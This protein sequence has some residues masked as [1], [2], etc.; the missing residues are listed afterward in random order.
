MRYDIFIIWGNGLA[1]TPQIMDIIRKDSNYEIVRIKRHKISQMKEFVEDIY[2]CDNVPMQHLIAKTRYLMTA[3]REAFLVLLKNLSPD[4]KF[5]GEGDFRHIQ[6]AKIKRTKNIIRNQFNPRFSDKSRQILPLD[7]GVSHEHCIHAT[8]YESQIDHI[9][10]VFGLENLKY[11][12]R[13]DDLEICFPF[14][15]DFNSY[16]IGE[17][18]LDSLCANIINEGGIVEKLKIEETPHYQY[19]SGNRKPYIEYFAKYFGT[20]LQEDHFPKS[21]DKLI[22]EFD[23][24]YQAH[25]GKKSHIIVQKNIIRDGLHRA[26]ILKHL[27]AKKVKCIQIS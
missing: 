6:C 20:F 17:V 11:H 2:S 22:R 13:Y 14:H 26:S 16:R 12:S 9:L 8:D 15:L 19:V 7:K 23:V 27:G 1:S 3:P 21:F 10:S 4:E 24:N 5:Y 18:E 25:S